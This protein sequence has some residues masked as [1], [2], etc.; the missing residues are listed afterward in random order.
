MPCMVPEPICRSADACLPAL[1]RCDLAGLAN[2]PWAAPYAAADGGTE[3]A[4][5]AGGAPAPAGPVRRGPAGCSAA[6]TS[7]PASRQVCILQAG[8]SLT[9][10]HA[11]WLTVVLCSAKQQRSVT[12]DAAPEPELKVYIEHL[13]ISPLSMALSFLPAAWAEISAGSGRSQAAAG[14]PELLAKAVPLGQS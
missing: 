12:Q 7:T 14:A 11:C 1:P 2:M 10:K 8:A 5:H 6:E 3:L 9:A 4:S 13:H